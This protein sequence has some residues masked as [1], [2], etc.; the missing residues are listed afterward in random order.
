MFQRIMHQNLVLFG[1]ALALGTIIG[2]LIST[3]SHA[4]NAIQQPQDWLLDY[5][6]NKEGGQVSYYAYCTT[7]CTG[8]R[9]RQGPQAALYINELT[10]IA[11]GELDCDGPSSPT[12]YQQNTFT[13]NKEAYTDACIA[14]TTPP[15][16]FTEPVIV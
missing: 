8:G 15:D 4:G 3:P 13:F 14:S 11:Y 6:C 5:A 9:C 7:G 2:F 16:Q 12:P 10:R 1:I